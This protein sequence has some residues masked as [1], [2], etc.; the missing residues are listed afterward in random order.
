MEA[1]GSGIAAVASRLSGIPELIRHEETGLLIPPGDDVAL[2]EA[3]LRLSRDADLRRRLASNGL[4]HVNDEFDLY[5]NAATLA[6]Y[7]APAGLG[8]LNKAM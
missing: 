3:L 6:A 2:A 7:F 8:S 5:K 4:A 1:L